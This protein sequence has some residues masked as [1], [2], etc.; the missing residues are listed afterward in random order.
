MG[1]T[2][3]PASPSGRYVLSRDGAE[4]LR[5]TESEVWRWIHRNHSYS[6]AHALLFE[7]YAVLPA[8]QCPPSP[9]SPA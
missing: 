5:G 6:V 9:A 3:Y 7:G 2:T 8:E 4:I 1:K